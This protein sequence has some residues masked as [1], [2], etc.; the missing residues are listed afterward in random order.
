M[1]AGSVVRGLWAHVKPRFAGP[2]VGLAVVGG[3][4]AGPRDVVLLA[5]HAALV[6][7]AIYVAHLRDGEVDHYVRGEDDANPLSRR[8]L[9]VAAVAAS[10]AFVV[11]VVVLARVDGVGALVTLPLLAL[12]WLHAPILDTR[13]VSKTLDY[14][15]GAALAFA[16]GYRVQAGA[17][18]P[19]VLALAFAY[20]CLLVSLVA[21]VDCA[22]VSADATRGKRTLPVA[23]GVAGARRTAAGL[24]VLGGAVVCA[25]ALA[26]VFPVVLAAAGALPAVAGVAGTRLSPAGSVAASTAATY[27][28]TAA[29]V[30]TYSL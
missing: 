29:L 19:W 25:G 13:P 4:L 12:A 23:L 28:L 16:G 9:R 15:V 5:G 11:G 26:G 6:A 17:V 18:P 20:V 22:D 1:T 21:R 8:A 27:A 24:S 3:V 30:A 14:P 2:A 10:V 7:L